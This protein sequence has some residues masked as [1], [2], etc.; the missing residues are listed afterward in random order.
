MKE[1]GW[2]RG[3]LVLRQQQGI[4]GLSRDKEAGLA[5]NFFYGEMMAPHD[6]III[7]SDT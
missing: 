2:E 1:D 3:D 7:M 6:Q 5:L 4:A